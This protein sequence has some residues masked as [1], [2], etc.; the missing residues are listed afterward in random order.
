[1]RQSHSVLKERQKR[2]TKSN[3]WTNQTEDVDRF[4]MQIKKH[5]DSLKKIYDFVLM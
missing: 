3:R 2:I 1:M 4:N 5:P